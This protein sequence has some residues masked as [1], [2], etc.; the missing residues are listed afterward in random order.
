MAVSSSGAQNKEIRELSR[1]QWGGIRWSKGG[2]ISGGMLKALPRK[3][4]PIPQSGRCPKTLSLCFL[5][6]FSILDYFKDTWDGS[7]SLIFK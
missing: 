3:K 2:A 4:D 7:N 1:P 6:R 5:C